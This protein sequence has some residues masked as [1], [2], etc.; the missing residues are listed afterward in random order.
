M[1]VAGGIV[2]AGCCCGPVAGGAAV[3]GGAEVGVDV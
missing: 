2:D 1:V 3:G